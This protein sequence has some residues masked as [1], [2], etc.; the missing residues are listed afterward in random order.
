MATTESDLLSIGDV[1]ARL[2]CAPSTIRFWETRGEIPR[3]RRAGVAGV[4][5]WGPDDVAKIERRVAEHRAD[6]ARLSRAA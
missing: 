1:A 6:R 5:L 2:K 4:R 3:A